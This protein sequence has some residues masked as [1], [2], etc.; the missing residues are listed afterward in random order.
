MQSRTVPGIDRDYCGSEIDELLFGEMAARL[1][2]YLIR[3]VIVG[4]LCHSS[5]PDE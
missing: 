1:V 2:V 5:F 3:H 4:D